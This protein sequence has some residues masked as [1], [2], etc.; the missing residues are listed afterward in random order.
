MASL[1]NSIRHLKKNFHILSENKEDGTLPNSLY[2]AL[3]PWYQ[4]QTKTLKEKKV[5][6]QF[7]QWIKTQNPQSII[8]QMNPVT[9]K[10]NNKLKL[11]GIYPR[12]VM[13]V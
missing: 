7:P 6:N 5:K 10:K 2:E 3:L 12:N 1:V 13:L 8:S 4:G 9:Y 11:S